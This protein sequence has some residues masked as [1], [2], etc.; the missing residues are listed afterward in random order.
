MLCASVL[1]H[2]RK[3]K[4]LSAV[5]PKKNRKP[6]VAEEPEFSTAPAV[7]TEFRGLLRINQCQISAGVPSPFWR[8]NRWRVFPILYWR[9][10]LIP[11]G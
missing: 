5:L 1:L 8:W 11:S 4:P 3:L 7:N 6:T 10:I 9:Q 2:S